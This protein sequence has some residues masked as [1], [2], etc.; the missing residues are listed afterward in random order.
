VFVQI[1]GGEDLSA[2]PAFFA[3]AADF[4]FQRHRGAAHAH[5]AQIK[6]QGLAEQ[7]RDREITGEVHG[8][9]APTLFPDD[10]VP[11]I[12][13]MGPEFFVH[14]IEQI[15][16]GREIGGAGNVAIAKAQLSCGGEGLGHVM[17]LALSFGSV[18]LAAGGVFG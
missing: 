12:A 5:D 8:G 11:G 6:G 14:A 9:R 4:M 10:L 2:G 16:I 1:G 18:C 13:D 7:R 15:Q 3:L 17:C